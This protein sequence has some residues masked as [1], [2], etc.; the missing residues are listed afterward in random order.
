MPHSRR[1]IRMFVISLNLPLEGERFPTCICE[2][3]VSTT[4]PL[5]ASCSLQ[6]C[7]R[8]PACI[9]LMATDSR[10]ASHG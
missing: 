2:H 3:S 4:F 1:E 7:F 9:P 10:G 8:I 6:P 5:C